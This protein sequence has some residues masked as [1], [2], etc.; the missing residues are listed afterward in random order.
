MTKAELIAENKRLKREVKVEKAATNIAGGAARVLRQDNERLQAK[1]DKVRQ[2]IDRNCQIVETAA[3]CMT[4]AGGPSVIRVTIDG[5][6]L[7]VCDECYKVVMNHNEV[8]KLF[9]LLMG[10]AKES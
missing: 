6:D 7:F 8:D 1:L 10:M 5:K 3:E 4:T 2:R 9:K